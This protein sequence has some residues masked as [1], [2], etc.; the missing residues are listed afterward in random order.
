MSGAGS[1]KPFN[2][3][4]SNMDRWL[5]QHLEQVRH[6]FGCLP[7][8]H[9]NLNSMLPKLYLKKSLA[10]FVQIFTETYSEPACSFQNQI[11]NF[12]GKKKLT[13]NI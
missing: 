10:D 12:I 6:F 9:F 3:F 5:V 7:S 11:E 2:G 1:Q 8:S 13:I 4:S